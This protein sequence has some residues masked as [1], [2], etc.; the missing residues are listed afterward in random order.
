MTALAAEIVVAFAVLAGVF[1]LV[2]GSFL[3]VV[4]YRVPAGIPLTRDSR[5]PECDTPVRAWQNVPVASWVALRG[6]CAGCRT[7]ISA[8]YP[9]VEVVTALAFAGIAAASL[10]TSS[11]PFG[12]TVVVLVA[13]LYF[14]AVSVVLTLI[15]QDTR[16]LPNAIVLP[17]YAV[18]LGLLALAC[19]AGADWGSFWR[20]V[21]G[22][23]LLY[24]FYAVLRGIRPG[25]MGGGDVKLAG[26]VGI[27]LAWLGW[28]SLA[29]G[30]FAA[31]VL[32]GVVG[33]ALLTLQR[34]GRH[35]AIPFGPWML[36]GAWIGILA[37]EPLANWYTG[38]VVA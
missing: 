29:V 26:V 35:T 24:A 13:Y 22:G 8:R 11:V 2:I 18:A 33:L 14:A 36:V 17:S 21:L 5:C 25:G 27:Y 19:V 9:V 1:G 30:A 38:L 10:N 23:A 7:P 15:D 4:A 34:A 6:R 37:G 16:R 31:F 28:G 12:P 20:A 32:G 3:N